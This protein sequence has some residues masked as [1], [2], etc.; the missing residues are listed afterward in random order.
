[1]V[2]VEYFYQ[3][4]KAKGGFI[5]KYSGVIFDFNGTLFFDSDK[6]EASWRAYS[7]KVRGYP[8]SGEEMLHKMHGR[9]NKAVLEYL[10]GQ[11]IEEEIL[12]KMGQEK[13]QLYRDMCKEDVQNTKLTPGSIEL[14]EFMIVQKI[15]FTI[16]TASEITNVKFFFEVF[17]LGKWFDFEK[18]VYDDGLMRGKPEPDIYLKAAAKIDISPS[19]C[20]VVED[21]ISGIEAA[22]CA[23]IGKIVAIGPKCNHDNL[24]KNKGVSTVISDFTE[25][26][27]SYFS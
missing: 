20:I 25:F 11:S 7:E 9:P 10:T 3:E 17:E 27:K 21:A 2:I 12:L 24:K 23:N 6:Q 19:K 16:A 26:D 13:E 14:F 4:Q 15:P 8:L 1:M 5:M 22:Y 18:V